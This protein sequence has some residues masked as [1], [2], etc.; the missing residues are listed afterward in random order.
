MEKGD[1]VKSTILRETHLAESGR[2]VSFNGWEMPVQY[3][4]IGQEHFAVR[5]G[6]GI[7]DVC[8]MG[9]LHISGYGSVSFLQHLL[10][11]DAGRIRIGALKYVVMCNEWGGAVDDLAVYRLGETEFMLVVNAGRTDTDLEWI[12]NAARDTRVCIEDRSADTGMVAIQGPEAEAVTSAIAGPGAADLGYFQF[13]PFPFSGCDLIVSRS[14]YTGE[15]GFEI[16]CPD[17]LTPELWRAA[18]SLGATPAGLGARDTLRTEMGYC[19]YGHELNEKITPLEA[20]LERILGLDNRPDQDYIGRKALVALRA[21]GGYRKLVGLAGKGRAVPRP[22]HE[23]L[24][25]GERVGSVSSGTYSPTLRTGIALA[26]VDPAAAAGRP[27]QVDIRG[28]LQQIELA[29]LPMVPS[30]VRT[31]RRKK[32]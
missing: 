5:S 31:R 30:R 27:L 11:V 12:R 16:M 29:S 6:V 22:G 23:I 13:A 25:D 26:F 21:Q 20:G 15:D 14:G 10:P 3:S 28:N 32:P 4:G 2:M 24:A 1:L 7:F 9:Q 18:R 17:A 8:H 19:L